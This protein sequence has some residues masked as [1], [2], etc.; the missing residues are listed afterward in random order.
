MAWEKVISAFENLHDHQIRGMNKSKCRVYFS[1]GNE[2]AIVAW[3]Y[4]LEHISADHKP[5][6]AVLVLEKNV[7]CLFNFIIF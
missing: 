4:H 5:R 7:M 1:I 2:N 6:T 3:L